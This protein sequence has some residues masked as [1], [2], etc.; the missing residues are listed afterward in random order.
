[1]KE[2]MSQFF[3]AVAELAESR[4]FEVEEVKQG[5]LIFKFYRRICS[6]DR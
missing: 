1:M 3:T 5:T 6:D 2:E 4:G